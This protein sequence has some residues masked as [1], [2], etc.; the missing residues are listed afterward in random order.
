V[1]RR[2]AG[3][4][5][6][7]AAAGYLRSSGYKILE[8]NYSTP[9]GEIDIVALDGDVVCFVEVRSR[10]GGGFGGALEALTK[11]KQRQVARAAKAYMKAKRLE[12]AG[13]R[14]DFA[15]VEIPEEG[16]A[17]VELVKNA[18]WPRDLGSGG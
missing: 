11:S 4:T 1:S 3:K 16:E 18:F 8:R 15:A 12:G 9:L 6:E 17:R 10:S 14:F 5:A 13:V 7:D 2:G